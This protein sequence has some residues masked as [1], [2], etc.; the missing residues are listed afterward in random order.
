MIIG[1]AVEHMKKMGARRYTVEKD[2]EDTHGTYAAR[3]TSP[4][5]QDFFTVGSIPQQRK[6]VI[7]RALFTVANIEDIPIIMVIFGRK[8]HG[9]KIF[10]ADEILTKHREDTETLLGV[11]GIRFPLSLGEDI[12]SL[13]GL[14][15]RWLQ[16]RIN[17]EKRKKTYKGKLIQEKMKRYQMRGSTDSSTPNQTLS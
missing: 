3:M 2:L 7:Q 8:P 16:M 13:K 9:V 4:D 17:W 15:E 10:S 14:K 6:A 12:D 5:L 11:V 1:D